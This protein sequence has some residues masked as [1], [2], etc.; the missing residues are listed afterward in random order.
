[1]LPRGYKK[2]LLTHENCRLSL[3]HCARTAHMSLP[4]VLNKLPPFL[5]VLCLEILFQLRL[6]LPE[7]TTRTRG[8]SRGSVRTG[9]DGP[10]GYGLRPFAEKSCVG[11]LPAAGP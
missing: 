3:A 10:T 7:H 2:W 6:G 11:P 1:M 4:F 9:T 8:S 5:N